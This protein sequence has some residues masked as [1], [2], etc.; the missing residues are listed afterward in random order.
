MAHFLDPHACDQFMEGDTKGA[1]RCTVAS[2][3]PHSGART[4]QT[5]FLYDS[6]GSDTR[7]VRTWL[8]GGETE[9]LEIGWKGRGIAGE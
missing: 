7:Q 1:Q 9:V 6:A 3:D 5:L 2:P 4:A 8:R